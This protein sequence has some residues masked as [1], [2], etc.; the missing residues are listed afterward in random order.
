MAKMR[1]RAKCAL[2]EDII[3]SKDQHDYVTCKCGEIAVD[4]G[5][6][7]WRQMAQHADNF[8]RLDDNDNVVERVPEKEVNTQ[9][10]LKEI[11]KPA[12]TK[13]ELLEHL[14]DLLE[15]VQN[16]PEHAKTIS[17][18]HYDFESLLILVLAIFKSV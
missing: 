9:E 3:E 18:N 10:I 15:R 14:K 17:I 16:M 8:L 13:D 4:G 1:N 5:Q 6:A 2:C 11:S 7:Y 12:P